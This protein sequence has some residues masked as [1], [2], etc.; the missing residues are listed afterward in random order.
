MTSEGQ[1]RCPRGPWRRSSD[2]TPFLPGLEK[3]EGADPKAVEL[4]L[5][6]GLTEFA[7]S[8]AVRLEPQ[9][10][11]ILAEFMEKLGGRWI[12][13]RQ[14]FV[15]PA[16]VPVSELLEVVMERVPEEMPYGRG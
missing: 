7:I 5:C 3:V 6:C 2:N 11:A 13:A 4:L 12:K 8:I 16:A 10:F 14:A 1:P 9:E 15:F